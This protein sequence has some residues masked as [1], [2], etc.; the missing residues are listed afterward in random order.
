VNYVPVAIPSTLGLLAGILVMMELGRRVGARRLAEHG[1]NA[2]AGVAAVDGAVFAVLGL[3]LAFTFSGAVR[4]S[5]PA[6]N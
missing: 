5:R 3:L 6:G 4:G 2:I 1:D